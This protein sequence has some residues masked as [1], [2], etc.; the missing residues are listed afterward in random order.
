M[1]IPD[2][3]KFLER[4]N[5]AVI[6]RMPS[7]WAQLADMQYLREVM[8]GNRVDPDRDAPLIKALAEAI[9]RRLK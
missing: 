5:T 4:D 3:A 9:A 2:I 1:N 8:D 7:G 6:C